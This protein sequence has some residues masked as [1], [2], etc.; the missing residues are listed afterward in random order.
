MK[1]TTSIAAVAAIVAPAFAAPAGDLTKR[2][3]CTLTAVFTKGTVIGSGGP[4]QVPVFTS[5]NFFT[6]QRPGSDVFRINGNS[7][8]SGWQT[9]PSSSTGTAMDV[10]FYSAFDLSSWNPCKVSYIFVETTGVSS[11]RTDGPCNDAG[12]QCS[13]C[14]MTFNC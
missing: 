1:F 14:V 10:S 5:D 13:Q 7:I 6:F 9:I 8:Q 12:Y 11:D 4:G 3:T 2:D